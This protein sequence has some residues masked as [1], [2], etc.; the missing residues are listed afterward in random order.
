M[1]VL[2]RMQVTGRSSYI[3]SLPKQWVQELKLN[4]GEYLVIRTGPDKTLTLAPRKAVEEQK[5]KDVEINIAPDQEPLSIVRRLIS[6]YLIGF[7]VINIKSGSGKFTSEQRDFIRELIRKKLVGAE[8]VTESN[9]K[10]TL[11]VLL[12]YPE[13][14]V[15]NAI[16]RMTSIAITMFQDAIR[17]LKDRNVS[18][19]ES[20][21]KMDDEVD[22][23]SF[24]VIRQ[25]KMAVQNQTLIRE[26][27]LNSP[28]DCLGFRLV[29]KSIERIADHAVNIANNSIKLMGSIKPNVYQDIHKISEFAASLFSDSVKALFSNNYN[30]ALQIVNESAQLEN[31]ENEINSHLF[32]S[33]IKA[34]DLSIIRLILES[35]K[36]VGEYSADIA[37][38][39]L[40]LTVLETI[41]K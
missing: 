25:L 15:D 37:E 35:V 3:V 20:V 1:E 2:R 24:Y 38:I 32:K 12:G 14:P 36:R 6:L 39:I 10:I 9:D 19:S 22:R 23:L 30:K 8:I 33:T 16:R 29:T 18:L 26:I 28:R 5:I 17:S 11:Q 21:I 7:N 34:E 40:N 4:R 13:F 31:M 41:K 27:G